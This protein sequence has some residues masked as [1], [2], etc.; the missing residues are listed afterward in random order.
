MSQFSS[1]NLAG[2]HTALFTPLLS[3]DPKRLRNSIDYAKA[4]QMIED[5][6]AVGVD[7]IVPVGTTGQSAT[8]S[9][10]QHLDMIRFTIEKVAGRCQVIAGAGSNCT[11]ESV[12]MIQAIQDIAP[13]PVLCVTGYYNNPTPDGVLQHYRTLADETDAQIVLYNVPGRTGSYMNDEVVIELAKHPKIIGL[14]QAVD[15]KPD[16]IHRQDTERILR[17]TKDLDFAVLSGEDDSLEDILRIGGTGIISATANIPEAA[18]M[19]KEILESAAKGDWSTAR[20]IQEAVLPFVRLV[21]CRKNPIPL[22]TLF[23]SPLFQPLSSV[24]DTSKGQEAV[25]AIKELV[26]TRATSL[27]KYW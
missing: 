18:K 16:G 21:F 5:L 17:K 7:G 24:I 9:H 10:S 11:R 15:F 4:G 3:D 23:Q 14:K 1:R 2:V 26:D 27:Q 6:I 8:L 22:G 19:F 12:D 25:E 20:H 13:V